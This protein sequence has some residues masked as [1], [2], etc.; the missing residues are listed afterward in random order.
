MKKKI[1]LLAG[2]AKCGTRWLSQTILETDLFM[3]STRM[4]VYAKGLK[5]S[6]I[7]LKLKDKIDNSKKNY[8]F[9]DLMIIKDET[10]LKKIIKLFSEYEII[11]IVIYRDVIEAL[12]SYYFYHRSSKN[13]GDIFFHN[14]EFQ[15]NNYNAKLENSLM[16]GGLLYKIYNLLYNYPDSALTVRKYFKNY[17]EID[18]YDLKKNP[19]F[20]INKILKKCGIKKKIKYNNLNN[21]INKTYIPRSILFEKIIWKAIFI[22]IGRTTYLNSLY[23]SGKLKPSLL[24]FFLKINERKSHKNISEHYINKIKKYYKED[25][26]KL[27]K[28]TGLKLNS[29]KY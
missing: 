8:F 27:K 3:H 16:P 1:L 19:Q 20:L 10:A 5:V 25:I 12:T 22:I 29:W 11:P 24:R 26:K 18:Y 9:L 6:D 15:V 2:H 7:N 4:K 13:F 28:I 14:K 23:R 21:H 17:I